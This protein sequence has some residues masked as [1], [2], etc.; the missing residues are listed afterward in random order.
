MGAFSQI[1]AV[2]SIHL[3]L[4][5]LASE[6]LQLNHRVIR[7]E[8]LVAQP[9]ASLP[10][11]L[12]AMH[13]PIPITLSHSQAREP[14]YSTSVGSRASRALRSWPMRASSCSRLAGNGVSS[15]E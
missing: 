8:S 2:L 9:E 3:Q 12:D 1:R 4:T 11:C 15:G 13:L 7:C 10:G 5:S 14:T 6:R